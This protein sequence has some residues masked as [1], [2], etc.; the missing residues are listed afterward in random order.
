MLTAY[1]LSRLGNNWRPKITCLLTCK[2]FITDSFYISFFYLMEICHQYPEATSVS[3]IE[4]LY[5]KY[6]DNSQS[7]EI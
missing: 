6:A 7:S 4:S 5:L 1:C 3:H 2:A